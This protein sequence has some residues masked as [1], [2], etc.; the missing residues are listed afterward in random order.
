MRPRRLHSDDV[1]FDLPHS[2][3]YCIWR[4]CALKSSLRR[5]HHRRGEARVEPLSDGDRGHGAVYIRDTVREIGAHQILFESN[6]PAVLPSTQILAI[7]Q[8]E[9]R[10]AE[11]RQV[12]GENAARLLRL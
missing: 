9:L 6:G 4:V 3:I 2:A 5:L 8:A 7:K 11:E 10:P 12:L 1:H